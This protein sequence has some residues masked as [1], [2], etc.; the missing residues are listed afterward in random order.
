[1]VI[2]IR[3]IAVDYDQ[4]HR[5]GIPLQRFA[6]ARANKHSADSL[7]IVTDSGGDGS[8]SIDR[9][10]AKE[11]ELIADARSGGQKKSL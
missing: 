7:R 8:M 1:M 6:C 5:L 11:L 10:T 2:S 3:K 4:Y 9:H